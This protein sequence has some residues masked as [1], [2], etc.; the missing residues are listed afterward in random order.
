MDMDFKDMAAIKEM[1]DDH[2]EV[3]GDR[4]QL[5]GRLSLSFW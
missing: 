3:D 2:R 4:T 5:F 1:M